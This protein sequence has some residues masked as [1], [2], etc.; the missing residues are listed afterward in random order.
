MTKV[1]LDNFTR[2]L[3]RQIEIHG[4]IDGEIESYA[5]LLADR[6]KLTPRLEFQADYI[7]GTKKIQIRKSFTVRVE[8]DVEIKLFSGAFSLINKKITMV[9]TQSGMSEVLWK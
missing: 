8:Q 6:Y 1:N 9:K 3:V 5:A 4:A 7:P 2:N